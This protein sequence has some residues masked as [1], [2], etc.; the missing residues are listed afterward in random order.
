MGKEFTLGAM[1]PGVSVSNLQD[2]RAGGH[3]FNPC[4]V[5]VFMR[6]EGSH[7]IK[8]LSPLSLWSQLF[9]QRLHWKVASGLEQNIV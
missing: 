1:S 6:I 2:L 4:F 8:I 5:N 9:V 3:W 7:C